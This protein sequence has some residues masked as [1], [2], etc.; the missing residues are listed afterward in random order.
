MGDRHP[1][2]FRGNTGHDSG[3]GTLKLAHATIDPRVGR[4]GSYH[5]NHPQRPGD[6]EKKTEKLPAENHQKQHQTDQNNQ[7]VGLEKRG[8]NTPEGLESIERI[9]GKRKLAGVLG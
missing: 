1:L 9:H 7:M 8:E 5:E 4:Q 2:R 3:A 6:T